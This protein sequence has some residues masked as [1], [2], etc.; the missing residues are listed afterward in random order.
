MERESFM[1]LKLNRKS[2]EQTKAASALCKRLF[3]TWAKPP[4]QGELQKIIILSW[5]INGNEQEIFKAGCWW[6]WIRNLFIKNTITKEEKEIIK[7]IAVVSA[8]KKEPINFVTARS[9]E[10]LHAQV[11]G[12]GNENLPRSLKAFK[13]LADIINASSE[14]V[15]T[16]A[17]V[18]FADLAIDNLSEIEKKCAIETTINKN[19]SKLFDIAQQLDF[20]KVEIKRMSQLTSPFGTLSE[21]INVDGTPKQTFQFSEIALKHIST[22]QKESLQ[23]HKKMFGW[24][25]KQSFSHTKNLAVTMGLVGSS[26]KNTIPQAILIHNESFISRGF[27]NNLFNSP[28]DPLPVICLRDLLE[29]KNGKD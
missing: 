26:I 18:I 10:F 4:T 7:I 12:N 28:D 22:A 23:S 16:K 13:K 25:E 6:L 19:L 9:P 8:C 2:I 17:T 1:N 11:P 3:P 15:P 20:Q 5:S 29:T 21:A 14:F 24:S 27:L